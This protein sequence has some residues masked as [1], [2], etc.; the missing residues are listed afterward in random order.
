MPVQRRIAIVLLE[1]ILE[2]GVHGLDHGIKFVA[3]ALRIVLI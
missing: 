2:E 3:L 1:D